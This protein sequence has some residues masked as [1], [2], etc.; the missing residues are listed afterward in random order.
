[1]SGGAMRNLGALLLI[2]GPNGNATDSNQRMNLVI[3]DK[4]KF[5]QVND[6][7]WHTRLLVLP[8]TNLSKLGSGKQR[9]YRYFE[10]LHELKSTTQ[11]ITVPVFPHKKK[12]SSSP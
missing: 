5:E 8:S 3:M 7:P 9:L 11:S 6:N 10:V 1:M 2:Y 12:I 4:S